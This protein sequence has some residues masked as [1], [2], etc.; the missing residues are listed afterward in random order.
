MQLNG[1]VRRR[2][3]GSTALLAMVF[4]VLFGTLAVGMYTTSRVS[5]DIAANERRGYES[6]LAAESGLAFFKYEIAQIDI[7]P[8]TDTTAIANIIETGLRARL[9]GKPNL[10]GRAIVRSGNT[11]AVP[12]V[13]TGPNARA[14]AT[15]TWQ[16]PQLMVTVGG[17]TAA[18][19]A[20]IP[21]GA[22]SA[23]VRGVQLAF[24]NEPQ[25]SEVFDYGIAGAGPI[26]VKKSV[27]TKILANPAGTAGMMS[28]SASAISIT[29]GSGQI[30]GN[31]AVVANKSQ[32]SLGG[33]AINGESDPAKI[34]AEHVKVIPP[35]TF[36][37][38]DTSPFKPLAVNTWVAGLP[39]QKNIRVPAGSNPT[40]N[41]G[42]V[43][44]GILYIESPNNVKFAGDAT[45]QGIIVFEDKNSPVLNS[46]DFKGNVQAS[47]IPNTSEFDAV[48]AA[49]VGLSI[50]A[51]TASVLMSGSVDGT[52][53]GSMIASQ[54][55]LGGSADL[56]FQHGT[57]VAL[58]STVMNMSGKIVSFTGNGGDNPPQM[59]LKFKGIFKPDAKTYREVRY[60]G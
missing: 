33:G 2:R 38:G 9:E 46:L 29:T 53:E 24:V 14:W 7:P 28:A 57:I 48:R 18:P 35:P 59:G 22:S 41:G 15:I 27:T 19:S 52:I 25:H 55:N 44:Q 21:T 8:N 6:Q 1:L 20:P 58:G 45:V 47:K 43:V 11:I 49:S 5:V 23:A 54:V 12:A 16:D 40:F 4:L 10:G 56:Y 50:L 13:Q 51:P 37:V 32:I 34:M 17:D 39:L 31:L 42:D 36:P 26:T 30:D 60:G 3:R